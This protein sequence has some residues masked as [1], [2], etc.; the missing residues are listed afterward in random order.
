MNKQNS[1][2][3]AKYSGK[4]MPFDR[5]KPR[6][7]LKKSKAEK[8]VIDNIIQQIDEIL[9]DCITTKEIYKTAHKLLYKKKTYC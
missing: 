3:V 2:F 6:K 8:K 7:S 1:I 9:D 5:G 4:P